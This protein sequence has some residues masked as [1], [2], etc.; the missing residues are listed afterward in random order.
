MRWCVKES[1]LIFLFVFVGMLLDVQ[2]CE[3]LMA[4]TFHLVCSGCSYINRS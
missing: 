4:R 1:D 3:S 2:R